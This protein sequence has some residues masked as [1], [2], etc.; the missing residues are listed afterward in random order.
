MGAK[1]VADTRGN[2]CTHA[3][4]HREKRAQ[5]TLTH[6]F[7]RSPPTPVRGTHTQNTTRGYG[8]EKTRTGLNCLDWTKLLWTGLLSGLLC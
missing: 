6:P 1:H 4:T 7:S 5:S 2:D 8:M 3:H